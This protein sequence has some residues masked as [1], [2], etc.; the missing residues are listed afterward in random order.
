MILVGCSLRWCSTPAV[1]RRWWRR[2]RLAR[3][4]SKDLLKEITRSWR[5][6]RESAGH[7]S[8]A[9][10]YFALRIRFW[11]HGTHCGRACH[12][13][14]GALRFVRTFFVLASEISALVVKSHRLDQ[15][16]RIGMMRGLEPGHRH[17]EF[18]F[19]LCE[20]AFQDSVRDRARDFAAVPRGALNH[21]C[22]D[23]LRMVK[24]RETRKP[25]DVFLLT[26][27]SGLRSARLSRYYPIFQ[28]RS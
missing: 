20:R 19:I 13:R 8:T 3:M 17:I 22:D 6:S 21:N 2:R 9:L 24:W 7:R 26:T 18:A 28:T 27:I 12:Q 16:E 14:S 4:Y 23:I 5:R 15:L 25:R 10:A 1:R 11:F